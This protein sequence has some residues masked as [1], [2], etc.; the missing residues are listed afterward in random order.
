MSLLIKNIK[1]PEIVLIAALAE[2]NRLIGKDGK[3][4]WPYIAEDSQR[5]QALTVRH[6][7]IMGRKTWELD[8]EKHPLDDRY[9]IVVS[10]SIRQEEITSFQAKYPQNLKFV[11][12]LEGALKQISETNKIFIIGG[13]TI[14]TQA[15]ELA[16]IWELTLIEGDFQGDTYFPEYQFLIGDKFE[17]VSTDARKGFKFET[18]RRIK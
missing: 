13:S 4:P 6:T 8:V 11:T 14:Y 5:F 2:N 16:D 15:L 7:V 9:N 3:L 12:S 17:L 18:Y 10:N 1:K